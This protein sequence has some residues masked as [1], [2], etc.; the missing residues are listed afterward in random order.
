MNPERVG[1]LI[2]LFQNEVLVF[3][4]VLK[5]FLAFNMQK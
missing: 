5:V 3:N 2:Y 4:Q 1:L